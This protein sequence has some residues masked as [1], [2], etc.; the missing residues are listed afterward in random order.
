MLFRAPGTKGEAAAKPGRGCVGIAAMA[1]WAIAPTCVRRCKCCRNSVGVFGL[2]MA[3]LSIISGRNPRNRQRTFSES[4]MVAPARAQSCRIL[5]TYS[6]GV[7]PGGC[8]FSCS[9]MN[10][11]S[12]TSRPAKL[13]HRA[14]FHWSHVSSGRVVSRNVALYQRRASS[15]RAKMRLFAFCVSDQPTAVAYL[16][17]S[18]TQSSKSSSALAE[19]CGGGP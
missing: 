7:S 4:S 1:C 2:V 5:D 9:W 15:W 6:R 10:A 13:S 3:T 17:Y 14:R 16:S 11:Q 12:L 18:L 19:K 8:R